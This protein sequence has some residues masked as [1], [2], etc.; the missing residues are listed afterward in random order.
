MTLE[1]ALDGSTIFTIGT[2]TNECYG[3]GHHG[4]ETRICREGAYGGG[5][6]APC[7]CT[8][9]DAEQYLSEMKWKH[10]KVVVELRL[11]PNGEI[12]CER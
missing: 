8:R 11:L 10:D 3:H 7:F 4:A 1:R 2:L 12:T 6:F 5:Q 9:S